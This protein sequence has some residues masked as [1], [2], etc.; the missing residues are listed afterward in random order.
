MDE[1]TSVQVDCEVLEPIESPVPATRTPSNTREFFL[2]PPDWRY[3]EAKRYLQDERQGKNAQVS[4]DPLVQYCI[5]GLRGFNNPNTRKF[6]EHFWYDLYMVLYLGT[7]ASHSA[8]VS[9]IES[10]LIHGLNA[11][12]AIKNGFHLSE[13]VYNLYSSLFFD[14]TGITAVHSWI[15]DF[16]FAPE[17]HSSHSQILRSRLVSYYGSLQSGAKA[18]VLGMESDT[19]DLIK[20]IITTERSKKLFDYVV[21]VINVDKADYV[22]MMETALKNMT[23]RDFQEHMRDRDEAGSSSLEELAQHLEDG[24]RAFSQTELTATNESGLDFD[25]KYTAI[26]LRKDTKDGK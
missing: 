25:N 23:E 2:R 1:L 5:R 8:V 16:L 26:V 14:L 21:K 18:S 19:D 22:M 15:N 7:F 20:K 4:D 17:Q 6:L 3:Q 9:E 24:I 12:Q 11:K 13:G 10:F